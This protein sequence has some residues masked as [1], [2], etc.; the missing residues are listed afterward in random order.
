MKKKNPFD[1]WDSGKT[2]SPKWKYQVTTVGSNEVAS[3]L[4][5]FYDDSP[6]AT[7]D[8]GDGSTPT[9]VISNIENFH[10]YAIAGTYT[11]QL[12]MANQECWLFLVDINQD[13][14]SQLLVAP[15]GFINLQ[16]FNVYSHDSWVQDITTWR[17]PQRLVIVHLFNEDLSGDITNIEYPITMEMFS[18][19]DTLCT[20]DITAWG[21]TPLQIRFSMKNTQV[22]AD[23]N[24][25]VL[26]FIQESFIVSNTL[27]SGVPDF[28]KC[29]PLWHFEYEDCDLTQAEV[30]LLLQRLYNR[31]TYLTAFS[32]TFYLGDSGIGRNNANPSGTY[33]N[34][35]PPMTGLEYVYKLVNDPDSEGFR[36]WEIE[37]H[38]TMY[39]PTVVARD[40]FTSSIP[41]D[42]IPSSLCETGP[43]KRFTVDTGHKLFIGNTSRM[44]DL[45]TTAHAAGSVN[46]SIIDSASPSLITRYAVDTGNVLSIGA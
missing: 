7:I 20:G 40:N 13:N 24:G 10:T 46:G 32:P 26:S 8:W 44:D 17:F 4:F 35:T 1:N 27:F 36:H 23:V 15:Q 21:Q 42:V 39:S 34:A 14:V 43:G 19:R 16:E 22:I 5:K 31:R 2:L 9:T 41:Y 3:V 11:I 12:V 37:T 28:S 29:G 30:D 25:W 45:F 18:M 33:H 38:S 6:D